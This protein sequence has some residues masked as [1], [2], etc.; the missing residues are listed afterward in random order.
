ME[1]SLARVLIAAV[2][3]ILI[4]YAWYSP[5]AFGKTWMKFHK[6]GEAAMKNDM[7]LR[8]FYSFI[9][10]FV[11]A[12]ILAF[13]EKHLAVSAMGGL[14]TGFLIWLGFVATVQISSVIWCKKPMNLFLINTGRHLVGLVVMGGILA[15]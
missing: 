2:I 13:F 9:M 6:G 7:G 14:L 15:I 1:I 11:M 4:G 10:S 8:V 5:F 3:N 12:Y